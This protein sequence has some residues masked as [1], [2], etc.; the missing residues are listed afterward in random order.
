M[1]PSIGRIA[2]YFV[3]G[4]ASAAGTWVFHKVIRTANKVDELEQRLT[5]LEQE[6][7]K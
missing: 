4:V 3:G 6:K 2:L 1:L 7:M 5:V